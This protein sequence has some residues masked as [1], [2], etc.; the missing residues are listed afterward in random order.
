[1][2][3]FL[4]VLLAIAVALLFDFYNGMNDAANS[5]S[6]VVATRV[7]TPA[8]AVLLAAFGNFAALFLF[9]V[10]VASTIGKGIVQPS[11]INE[12]IILAGVAGGAAW[13]I[14]ATHRGLPIS[15]SHALIGG[16]IG[17][18]VMAKGTGALITTGI[19]KVVAFILIAPVVGFVGGTLFMA[20]IFRI[21][22]KTTP[23]RV[24]GHFKRLQIASALAY[25]LSHGS[26]DAQ[27][28]MGII[29]LLLF[30]AGY[31]GTE[32]H[33]PFWIALL[34]YTTISLGTLTG[35]WKVVQTMGLKITKLRPVG[36][37]CAESA[38]ALTIFA[39]S[40]AGIPVSTTHVITG[41]IMGVGSVKR[42]S[43]VRWIV[44]RGI[45]AAWGLTIPVAMTFAAITY[46]IIRLA[47]GI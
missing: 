47:T 29:A 37:F 27:K 22:R 35:G 8:K 2:A 41:S 45:L 12:Y 7:L 42:L 13:V 15:A 43:A 14:I 6:T 20:A 36:G 24:N 5:I 21:F 28:T 16:V 1:M 3:E 44:A 17:A 10:A 4:I 34:S 25:S 46:E 23:S 11:A 40:F 30:S 26:N 38:G 9:G 39:S 32:F 18:T 31:L 33:I 19:L